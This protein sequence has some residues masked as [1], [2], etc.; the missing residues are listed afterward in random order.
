MIPQRNISIHELPRDVIFFICPDC[1]CQTTDYELRE[2]KK[3]AP[4]ITEVI[5][6]DYFI[7]SIPCRNCDGEQEA[8]VRKYCPFFIERDIPIRCLGSE[9]IAWVP[10]H[11]NPH[12]RLLEGADV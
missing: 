6:G 11:G 2:M 4:P 3:N 7:Y 9:C 8:R 12:C 10:W 5:E 1:G